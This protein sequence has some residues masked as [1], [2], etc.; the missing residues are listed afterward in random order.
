MI[1]L[2]GVSKVYDGGVVALK[3]VNLEVAKGEFVFVVG[4]S[5]S[6]KST[7]ARLLLRDERPTSGDIWV[8]GKH[9]SELPSWKVPYLRR[10]M[11]T[12][13]QDFKLL[14][15]KTVEE[16]VAF[17]LEVIGRPRHVVRTQVPQVLKLVGLSAKADRLPMQLS[18]G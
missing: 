3:D 14:P 6:G 7:L 1:R 11:G 15:K 18:G 12:V 13:F 8:A 16:N 5:G 17:A 10:S 9:V 4:P 2:Q